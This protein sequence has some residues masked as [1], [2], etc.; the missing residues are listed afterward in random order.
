MHRLFARLI[1][2]VAIAILPAIAIV[3]WLARDAHELRE[4][5]IQEEVLRLLATVEAVQLRIID[6]ADQA[7]TAVAATQVVQS[8]DRK[9]CDRLLASLLR[10]YDRYLYAYVAAPDGATLCAPGVTGTPPS[11]ADRFYFRKALNTD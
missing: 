10:Q 9:A 3:G 7:L 1:V 6:G 8:H 2:V 5:L 11:A 4:Q